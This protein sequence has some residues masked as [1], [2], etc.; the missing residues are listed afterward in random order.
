MNFTIRTAILV[1]V[2][3]KSVQ[4]IELYDARQVFPKDYLKSTLLPKVLN[5]YSKEY[6]PREMKAK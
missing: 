4:N 5:Q 2:S 1:A 3:S 6:F